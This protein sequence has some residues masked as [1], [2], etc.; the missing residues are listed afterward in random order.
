[1]SLPIRDEEH[2]RETTKC[3]WKAILEWGKKNLR[4]YPWR[5]DTNSYNILIAEVMLHRTRADQ[6]K[7]IYESFIKNYPD[8]KSIINAGLENIRQ[9]L[10]PLGL[11][12]RSDLLYIMAKDII[13]RYNGVVPQ[14]KN[15]LI[16]LP[17][18]GQYIS[19]AI[20]CFGY[21]KKEPV[22]DTN[23]VRVISR[24][25]GKE[26]KDSSRK[27]KEFK[28]I[29]MDLI[30]Y[31]EPRTFTLSLIDFAALICRSIKPKCDL[32]SLKEIC[33]YMKI[34]QNIASAK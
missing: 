4:D 8:F 9:E 29:M 33:V 6:V 20:L 27:N 26:A 19:S 10:Y 30:S 16:K 11:T 13:E 15:M 5:N 22:L 23:V 14:D 7:P 21:N 31:G 12:W 34:R 32:C 24:L 3:V 28:S 2:Y 18:V 17:G 1:L 25:F